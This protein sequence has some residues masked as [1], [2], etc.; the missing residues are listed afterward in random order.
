MLL[1]SGHH[2]ASLYH[3]EQIIPHVYFHVFTGQLG[4]QVGIQGN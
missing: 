3:I 2:A 4:N 1:C